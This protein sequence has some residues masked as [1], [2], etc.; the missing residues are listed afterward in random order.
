MLTG[1]IPSGNSKGKSISLT[2]STAGGCLHP[3]TC[4]PLYLHHYTSYVSL[5]I[6][7][8]YYPSIS[9]Y[10]PPSLQL[11]LSV[12]IFYLYPFTSIII[13]SIYISIPIIYLY[14]FISIIT[15]SIYLSSLSLSS[16]PIYL[17]H[18]ISLIYLPLFT[19]LP[20]S[21]HLLFIYL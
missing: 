7:Y 13:S 3:L 11:Y 6:I 5:S 2:F 10:L 14:L 21:L 17:H 12:S 16:L 19:Y 4:S 15:A 1:F 18:S 20:P 9:T 8:L